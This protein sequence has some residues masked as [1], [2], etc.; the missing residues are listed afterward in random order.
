MLA[1]GT[2]VEEGTVDVDCIAT[3]E[4]MVHFCFVIIWHKVLPLLDQSL[5]DLAQSSYSLARSKDLAR[6]MDYGFVYFD[7]KACIIST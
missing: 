6:C 7:R 3:E 1:I 2:A 5:G 4:H